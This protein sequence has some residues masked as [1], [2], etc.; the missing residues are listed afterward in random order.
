MCAQLRPHS[1]KAQK[2]TWPPRFCACLTSSLGIWHPRTFGHSSATAL[3]TTCVDRYSQAVL[4]SPATV[5]RP[6]LVHVSD[7]GCSCT[8]ALHRISRRAAGVHQGTVLMGSVFREVA[9]LALRAVVRRGPLLVSARGAGPRGDRCRRGRGGQGAR[10]RAPTA[11]ALAFARASAHSP[12]SAPASAPV[13]AP[14]C[15]RARAR[16]RARACVPSRARARAHARARAPVGFHVGGP[17]SGR[18]R[19]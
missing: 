4:P 3:A 13:R 5:S 18:S 1:K 17:P 2:L 14:I 11:S 6:V 10:S 7:G 8:A 19:Q 12:A 15:A 16:A 9:S